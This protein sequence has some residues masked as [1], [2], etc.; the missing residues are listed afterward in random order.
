MVLEPWQAILI[1]LVILIGQFVSSVWIKATIE[2][3]IRSK[4]ELELRAKQQAEKVAEYMALA[5]MLKESSSEEDYQRAN[6]LAWELAIWLPDKVYKSMG[7]ALSKPN[8]EFNPLS[9]VISV[10]KELLGSAA[11]DLTQA[12]VIHHA[13]GI[14]K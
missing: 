6:K 4:Y 8:S 12:E 14:G 5:R 7:R 10:R 2:N 11:G 1:G 13:P 3:S 9:V